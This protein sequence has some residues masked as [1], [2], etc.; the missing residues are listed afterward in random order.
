VDVFTTNVDGPG[1]LDV[2]LDRAVAMDGVTVRYFPTRLGRRLYRSPELA[3]ALRRE[4]GSYDIVHVHAMFLWPEMVAARL[5]HRHGIPFVLSPRG[6]LVKELIRQRSRWLKWAWIKLFDQWMIEHASFIHTTSR[7][8]SEDLQAF[9]LSLPAVS[10]VPNGVDDPEAITADTWVSEDVRNAT[11]IPY[12]LCLGR[13]SWKKNLE[14]LVRVMATIPGPNLVLA[15]TPEDEYDRKILKT[16]RETGLGN[17]LHVLPRQIS[18]AD[19]AWLFKNCACFV[20]P[21][22]SENFGNVVLEAMSYGRPVVTARGV[23]ASVILEDAQCGLVADASPEGLHDALVRILSQPDQ[24]RIM[25]ERG[26]AAAS[27]SYQW[28]SVARIMEG[29]YAGALSPSSTAFGLPCET[30]S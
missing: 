28:S 16:G 6:M 15:G 19:K 11:A 26:R 3:S 5:A 4:I 12:V 27:A 30:A 29:L 9:G 17:R 2:P 22:L 21:S 8:E 14:S 20:L 23:G 13:L 1:T 24:A 7:I 18:G 25:G 10:V